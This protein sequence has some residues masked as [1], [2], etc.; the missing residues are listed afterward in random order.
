MKIL[1]SILLTLL[2]L[3][4]GAGVQNH[5]YAQESGGPFEGFTCDDLALDRLRL[6][7]DID[8]LIKEA[9]ENLNSHRQLVTEI[10]DL[11]ERANANRSK[12]SKAASAGRAAEALQ[13]WNSARLLEQQAKLKMAEA[14][15]YFRK[16]RDAVAALAEKFAHLSRI[17]ALLRLLDCRRDDVESK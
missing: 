14:D 6:Q 17:E 15:L 8:R 5:A 4:M 2:L 1:Q 13:L 10:L 11:R 16:N 7:G 12:A 3:V 9:A